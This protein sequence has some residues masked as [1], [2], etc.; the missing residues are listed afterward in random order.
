M[1]TIE[2]FLNE[3]RI[4]PPSTEFAKHA[5]LPSMAAYNKLCAQAEADYLGFWGKQA[6]EYILWQKPFTRILDE[7]TPPFYK[8][9]DDGELNVSYNCLDRHLA[10]QPDKTAIILKRMMARL[11]TQV[12]VIF[13]NASVNLRTD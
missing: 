7:S 8:W 5:N 1:S 13:I 4:F 3:T 9:F 2:S 11:S 12:T 10:T 6:R